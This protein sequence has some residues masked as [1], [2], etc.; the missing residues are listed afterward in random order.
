MD[1]LA[2][3]VDNG[4]NGDGRL[5]CLTVAD[6]QL[7][8]ATSNGDHGVD[9]LDTCLKGGVYRFSLDYAVGNA[10]NPAELIGLNR[11]FSVQRL[12]QSIHNTSCHGIAYRNLYHTP[13][14]LHRVAFADPAGITKQNR[15]HVVLFQVQH[16][17]VDL[18]RKLQKFSLHGA[19]KTVDAG[20]TV[21]HLDNGTHVGN[22]KL[23]RILFYLFFDHRTNFF[24]P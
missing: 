23:G 16:H 20:D 1:A 18:S 17:A 15:A 13:G 9:G 2:L 21:G 8:L 3:L 7:T 14:S 4:V 19:F 5:T 10:L 6:N 22:L 24:R 11:S 12:S